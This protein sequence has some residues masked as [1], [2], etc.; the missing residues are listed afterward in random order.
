MR[1][2]DTDNPELTDL[3][4]DL[5]ASNRFREETRKQFDRYLANELLLGEPTDSH[6]H[7]AL[8]SV[9]PIGEAVAFR[10]T[11]D[12]RAQVSVEVHK[13]IDGCEVE[14]LSELSGRAPT[15]EAYLQCRMGASAAGFLLACLEYVPSNVGRLD[16]LADW[17]FIGTS[18]VSTWA[19]LFER[20][21]M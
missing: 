8:R 3:P 14:Q 2:V 10:M 6:L 7:P 15:I 5:G 21:S 12:Q 4:D 16:I 13:Y 11:R 17:R 1:L 19:I 20:T 9:V 18:L